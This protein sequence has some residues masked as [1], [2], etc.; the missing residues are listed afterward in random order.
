QNQTSFLPHL[1]ET[2]RLEAVVEQL[3][4]TAAKVLQSHHQDPSQDY[5]R[6]WCLPTLPQAILSLSYRIL[7]LT[8]QYGRP[9]GSLSRVAKNSLLAEAILAI[10]LSISYDLL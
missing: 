3:P 1:R 10:R 7:P 4:Q 8:I 2:S 9:H 5:H 6:S